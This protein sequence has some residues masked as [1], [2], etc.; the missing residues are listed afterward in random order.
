MTQ[1]RILTH[2]V[3]VITG[4]GC[5]AG[6][7]HHPFGV[8]V[9]EDFIPATCRCSGYRWEPYFGETHSTLFHN[10]DMVLR[11]LPDGGYSVEG[12]GVMI[13]RE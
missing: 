9:L 1:L 13:G 3:K 11:M 6:I 2:S 12:L 10:G 7:V 4:R 8:M 5:A